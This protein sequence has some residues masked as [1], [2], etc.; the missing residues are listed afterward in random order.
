MTGKSVLCIAVY[1]IKNPSIYCAIPTSNIAHR[2]TRQM[3]RIE[4]FCALPE[5]DIRSCFYH[6]GHTNRPAIFKISNALPLNEKYIDDEYMSQGRHLVMKN[7][8]L[9]RE[10]NKKL[11]RIL[12]DEQKQK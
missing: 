10:I 2:D 12:F 6:I 11:S 4:E 9:I 8:T 3:K 5:R 7:K 1:R